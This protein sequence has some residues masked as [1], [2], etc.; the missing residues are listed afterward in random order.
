MIKEFQGEY[1]YLSN[2]YHSP[3]EYKGIKYLNAEAAF[4]AQKEEGRQAEFSN[5]DPSQA[6]RLG[7]QVK[8]R[9]DWDEVKDQIMYEVVSRK[10]LQNPPLMFK[11]IHTDDQELEEGNS[12]GD[13]YWG[14]CN[15]TGQ[16]KL[17]KILMTVRTLLR[18]GN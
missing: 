7:R 2:F 3:L 9:S 15:G 1:R 18:G 16:N 4:Q 12:W 6:K 13:T 11:L 8:L 10:F 17:G 5:L 14:V